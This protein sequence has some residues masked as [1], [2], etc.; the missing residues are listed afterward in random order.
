LR[1]RMGEYKYLMCRRG[2]P[3]VRPYKYSSLKPLI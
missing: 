1:W 2:E 3:A